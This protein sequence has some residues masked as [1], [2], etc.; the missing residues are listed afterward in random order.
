MNAR[1]T[2]RLSC[3]LA[4]FVAAPALAGN[5]TISDY[6]DG[7]GPAMQASP[8]GCGMLAS[9]AFLQAGSVSVSFTDT[10]EIADAGNLLGFT[11]IGRGIVDVVINVYEGSFDPANPALN[12]VGAIDEGEALTLVA[13]QSYIIVIQPFCENHSGV[14]AVVIRGFG[15]ISGAGFASAAHTV[16]QHGPGDPVAAFPLGIGSHHYDISGPWQAVRTGIHYFGEVGINFDAPIAL[17]A[18]EGAFDPADT[19]A[20][21]AGE[22]SFVGGFQF[23]EGKT[24]TFV[25]VDE[26]DLAGEWQYVL[27]PPGPAGFNATLRGAWVTPG[28]DGS[29]VLLELGADTGIAFLAWFTFP[30][31][32]SAQAQNMPESADGARAE[33]A[34][35]SE[36]Q[37]WLTG[38]G[39]VPASGGTLDIKFENTTGGRFNA[40]TPK[41]V[42]DSNYGSGS[43]ELLDCDHLVIHY[44]LPGGVAGSAPMQRAIADNTRE[45][46]DS[47]PAAPVTP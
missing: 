31:A 3:C 8:A 9:Q 33:A 19:S 14:F 16:G 38:F 6:F 11:G 10:Y 13:G 12:R 4:L 25:A 17:L 36:D 39:A 40:P 7:D 42:T 24:Y 45:C 43:L 23:E 20:N 26:N 28:V 21:L 15:T 47:V 5:I 2:R 29:G 44:E 35:G 46:L 32:V 22:A 30:E 41:P 34:V 37:R 27:F 18:Y 1:I